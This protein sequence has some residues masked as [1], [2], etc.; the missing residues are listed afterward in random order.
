MIST[1]REFSS[2]A[3]YTYTAMGYTH[4][5]LY[6]I[7]AHLRDDTGRARR[8]AEVLKLFVVRE[9]RYHCDVIIKKGFTEQEDVLGREEG[10]I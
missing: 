1:L 2:V 5:D 6:P 9:K 10:A 4:A 8:C 3:S 7:V